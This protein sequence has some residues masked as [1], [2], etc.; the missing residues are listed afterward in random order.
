VVIAV[1]ILS[2]FL[3]FLTLA[4]SATA[5]GTRV[6]WTV[7]V[8]GFLVVQGSIA[9][10][11]LPGGAGLAEAGLL[12][13]LIGAGVAATPAAALV[14]VYRLISWLGLSV[15]GWVVYALAP[16]TGRSRSVRS[17]PTVTA[18]QGALSR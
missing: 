2:W 10:Q 3:D 11:I 15:A 4:A 9:L 7:L 13:V 14:L 1:A 18:A 17:L 6:P 16:H 12:G 8:V 5:T